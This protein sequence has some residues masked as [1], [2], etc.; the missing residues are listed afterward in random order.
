MKWLSRK[1]KKKGR[2][3]ESKGMEER[4]QVK[5]E[6]KG[7]SGINFDDIIFYVSH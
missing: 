5:K 4:K 6:E 1:E 3:V 7:E 2:K